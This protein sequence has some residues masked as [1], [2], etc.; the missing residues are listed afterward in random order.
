MTQSRRPVLQDRPYAALALVAL[1]CLGA[2]QLRASD[3]GKGDWPM[4]GG[5]PDRNLVSNGLTVLGRPA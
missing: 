2:V 3:P 1:M 5:T 4:W